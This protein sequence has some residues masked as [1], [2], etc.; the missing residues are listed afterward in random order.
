MAVCHCNE[1][2]ENWQMYD[3]ALTCKMFWCSVHRV[4]FSV[5]ERHL[6]HGCEEAVTNGRKWS[7]R[8]RSLP[9][10]FSRPI[11]ELIPEPVS[12]PIRNTTERTS[13][14]SVSHN[15]NRIQQQQVGITRSVNENRRAREETQRTAEPA[16]RRN[17][18]N[19]FTLSY[20]SL[21]LIWIIGFIGTIR[22]TLKVDRL[23]MDEIIV[24]VNV[25]LAVTMWKGAR[26][27]NKHYR[28]VGTRGGRICHI[29]FQ[30]SARMSFLSTAHSTLFLSVPSLA[31]VVTRN[32][33]NRDV[34]FSLIFCSVTLVL[35][36]VI[37][38][39]HRSGLL[40]SLG[41]AIAGFAAK[42]WGRLV[43][44]VLAIRNVFNLLGVVLYLF[45]GVLRGGVRG[46]WNQMPALFRR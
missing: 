21:F 26:F 24:G 42:T 6:H 36:I 43:I 32:D 23:F 25:L 16:D 17:K 13:S 10:P 22:D 8:R 2:V 41:N 37:E 27:Q 33:A 30:Q 14:P 46:V 40:S 9:Q 12:E 3:H 18:L 35:P 29:L 38:F 20:F 44:M 19:D 1:R 5:L 7:D 31:C 45:I 39:L 28:D 4:H 15:A 34:R 11:P